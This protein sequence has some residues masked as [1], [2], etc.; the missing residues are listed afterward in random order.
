[1]HNLSPEQQVV[2]ILYHELNLSE[3]DFSPANVT[4]ASCAQ[5]LGW[6]ADEFRETYQ[7]A[8]SKMCRTYAENHPETDFSEITELVIGELYQVRH[9]TYQKI[10]DKRNRFC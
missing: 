5:Q 3:D 8:L 7:S 4:Y 2:V 9:E 1:M 10:L 6:T